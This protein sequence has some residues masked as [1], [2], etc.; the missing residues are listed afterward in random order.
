MVLPDGPLRREGGQPSLGCHT[1]MSDHDLE[2]TQRDVTV[3][4]SSELSASGFE[5]AE[6]IGRG[7]SGVV[8]R[9]VQST[10]DRTVAVK[11]LAHDLSDAEARRFISEQ[12]VMGRLTGHPNIV[13]VLQAGVTK[14]GYRYL[15]MPYFAQSSLSSRIRSSGPIPTREA[16]RVGV[17]L[18]GA[19]ATAHSH[20]VIHRDVKPANILIT[21]YGEPALADFGIA[22]TTESDGDDVA[23]AGSLA[24]IAPELF[25]GESPTA[26]ADVYGLGVTLYVALA[27][28]EELD[29]LAGL[30]A[31]GH[32]DKAREL[33]D[34]RDLGV[35][36]DM[37][38]LIKR[39]MSFNPDA[40][41]AVAEVGELLQSLQAQFHYPVDQMA[42]QVAGSRDCLPQGS[43]TSSP[44]LGAS[45]GLSATP[46]TSLLELTSFVGRR[47]ELREVR[48]MFAGS[49]LV[50]L[51]GIGGVG[52]T[53]LA[54]KVAQNLRR[55]FP[56]GV[57]A[58]ELSELND[59]ALL[60]DVVAAGL[61]IRHQSARPLL[62]HLIDSLAPK[63]ALLLLDNCEQIVDAVAQLVDRLL[64]T[65]PSVKIMATSREPLGIRGETVLRVPPL[66]VPERSDDVTR[67]KD[68]SGDAV[69][70]FVERA[71][72][73]LPDFTF[74]SKNSAT[75]EGIC[76]RLDGL[77]LAIELAAARL[78]ALSPD[79]ILSRLSDRFALL[80]RGNRDAP[81]RQ[82][83]LSLCIGWSYEM[84]TPAEQRVW[85]Q[86]TVFA[87]GF[88]LESV[89]RIIDAEDDTR[90]LLNVLTSLVDKSILIREEQGGTV[91]FR[92]LDTLRTFARRRDPDPKHLEALRRR[93]RDWYE[94]V[95]VQ[96]DSEWFSRHQKHW[97]AY[98]TKEQPNLRE[99]LEFSISDDAER[100][101]ALRMATALEPFWYSVGLLSEGRHWLN[102]ALNRTDLRSS[103]L[104]AKALSRNGRLTEGLEERQSASGLAEM[105]EAIAEQTTDAYTRA[106]CQLTLGAHSVYTGEF[107][108]ARAALAVT[109]AIF[110]AH[111][112]TPAQV[113][114]LLMLGW[115]HALQSDASKALECYEQ[116]LAITEEHGESVS[117]SYVLWAAA[118]ASWLQRDLVIAQSRL[119]E[120]LQLVHDRRDPMMAGI[121]LEVLAWVV[122]TAGDSNRS[123]VLMGAAHT[124]AKQSG[125]ST[126]LFTRLQIHH[127]TCV[128]AARQALGDARFEAAYRRGVE[129]DLDA[130]VDF[131]FGRSVTRHGRTAPASSLTGREWQVAALVAEGLTNRGIADRLVISRRT[132]EGHVEHILTKLGYSR[133][134]Q[135][136]AWVTQQ[137]SAPPV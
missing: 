81:D 104:V 70:L 33:A 65:C 58:I 109:H 28:Y 10:L 38:S 3:S 13:S 97:I 83:T 89:E 108:R 36:S 115:A 11:V 129:L 102:R 16:L 135:I 134:A 60:T 34:P 23:V 105:A 15:V 75:V 20:G 61:G 77:P 56:D 117:R 6:E 76:R 118:Y 72:A 35:A 114:A 39:C 63:T 66:T 9:C 127:D 96:A 50:T 64:R 132:A 94:R 137:G 78:P 86:L 26:A 2:M 8:Y 27:G 30:S 44:P 87:G 85:K 113:R 71:A 98:L 55:V 120:G 73:V 95:A 119:D 12:K 54:I 1:T 41:P 52:K 43:E 116:A 84:C 37:V 122:A 7:G 69:K 106:Y 46:V 123:S 91:R 59:P 5:S 51:T 128:A 62:D 47:A 48:Q 22:H 24:F 18:C 57:W 112:D 100:N 4:V 45:R 29:R 133:R 136:A 68:D 82:Q 74:T 92:M 126:V 21:D 103:A 121:C 40:R 99:A 79:Q 101:S 32:L 110:A 93:H 53:R 80:T 88:D 49:R 130:A 67:R 17:R 90:D 42:I 31:R 124:Q 19:L 131:A 25:K 125:S 14:N 107:T 111:G